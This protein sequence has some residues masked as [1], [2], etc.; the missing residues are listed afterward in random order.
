MCARKLKY[1]SGDDLQLYATPREALEA[2]KRK[3]SEAAQLQR[4]RRQTLEEQEQLK[5]E[6]RHL[7]QQQ[8]QLQQQ[9]QLRQQQQQRVFTQRV[10]SAPVPMTP[11][12][13]G[14]PVPPSS[15]SSSRTRMSPT[16]SVG[17]SGS[18]QNG[19]DPRDIKVA[20]R[21]FQ[22]HDVKERGR[23][24]GEELQNLLQNDDNSRFSMSSIDSLINLFGVARF[25]TVNAN[26]FISLYKKLK[27][28]RKVYVDNDIDGSFT[29]SVTEYHNC[30]QE[31]RYLI[32]LE[33]S[34]KLFDQY[35]EFN[36]NGNTNQKELKFDKF[37]ESLTWLMKLT[38][39]FRKFDSK[40][41]GIAT[42]DYKS[43]IESTLYLGRF[44]PH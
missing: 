38:S 8:L 40:Q 37:V 16:K 30:L 33:A 13:N 5:R 18:S 1:S 9:Q 11:K 28:W 23:L 39:V 2:A 6:K 14:R 15:S 41:E 17:S 3:E 44:L 42:I 31:L 35:S 20:L 25:G 36:I 19:M 32:P 29:I 22:N 10:S 34:E 12:V 7:Q 24:T 21:L 43:F 4:I 26:E 27:L